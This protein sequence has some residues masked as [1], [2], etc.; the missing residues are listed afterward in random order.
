MLPMAELPVETF[1]LL[2]KQNILGLV[3]I[4]SPL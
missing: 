2:D 3:D 1:D 4:H